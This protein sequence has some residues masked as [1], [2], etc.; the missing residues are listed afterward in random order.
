MKAKLFDVNGKEKKDIEL[1]ALFETPIRLDLCKKFLE[2]EK[3]ILRQPY[4]N[5][6]KAGKRHSASGQMSMKRH[7]WKAHYG[8]GISRVPRKTMWRRGVQFFWIG[9]EISGTR[10]GRRSHPPQGKYRYRKINKK[11]IR[12]AF[13]SAF[14]ATM[15]KDLI[16]KRYRSLNSPPKF[17]IL[18]TL[19]KKTKEL[20]KLLKSLFGDAFS[21]VMKKK[22]IRS[23][24]GK[25][26]GRKYKSNAGLLILTGENEEFKF[27]GLD[28]K[29]INEVT[30]SDLYPLGRIT[31]YTEKALEDLKNVA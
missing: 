11:E 30:M 1:P 13:N 12:T 7:D 24:K 9:A 18:E 5:D 29:K 3:F 14:A 16:L 28:V 8:K 27:T 15:D 26:R 17:I 6:E 4:S 19:P 10:G 20:I 23:G 21:I 25:K 22:E 31:V 2:S